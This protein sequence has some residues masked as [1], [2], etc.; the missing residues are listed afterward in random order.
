MA[1][2]PL[3]RTTEQMLQNMFVGK[4][5]GTYDKLLDYSHPVTGTL[6]FAPSATFLEKVASEKA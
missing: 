2:S 3:T 4:P 1:R 5:P 6:F